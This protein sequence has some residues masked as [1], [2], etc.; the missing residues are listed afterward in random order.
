[1]IV[2]IRDS[3]SFLNYS[4]LLKVMCTGSCS[5]KFGGEY[6]KR[7]GL[8]RNAVPIEIALG[9]YERVPNTSV[10]HTGAINKNTG[11]NG[12]EE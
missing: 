2:R 4:G 7:F 9:R 1:M 6:Y 12:V 3:I 10:Q 8:M 11:R 5:L